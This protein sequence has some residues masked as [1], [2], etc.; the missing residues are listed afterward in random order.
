M[1]HE[2]G[3]E[4]RGEKFNAEGAEVRGDYAEGEKEGKKPD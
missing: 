1:G 2:G 3:G 4:R